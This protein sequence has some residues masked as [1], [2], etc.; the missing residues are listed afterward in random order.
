M[1][2]D[3]KKV[4]SKEVCCSFVQTHQDRGRESKMEMRDEGE[5][6]LVIDVDVCDGLATVAHLG[7][8]ASKQ[9]RGTNGML[10][11]GIQNSNTPFSLTT[12]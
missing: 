8:S 11:E 1:Y 12:L 5:T 4:K 6:S 10:Q 9:A 3:L 2:I 7:V